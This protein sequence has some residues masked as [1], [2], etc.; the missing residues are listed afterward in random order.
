MGARQL[1]SSVIPGA[2]AKGSHWETNDAQ[3]A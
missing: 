2:A 3:K 1:K